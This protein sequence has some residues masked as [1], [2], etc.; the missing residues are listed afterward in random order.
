MLVS[1]L[2][3]K[4]SFDGLYFVKFDERKGLVFIHFRKNFRIRKHEDNL[5]FTVTSQTK[6][7]SYTCNQV[8]SP[9][10]FVQSDIK[11]QHNTIHSCLHDSIIYPLKM[12]R[13]CVSIF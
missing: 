1:Y 2:S 6:L 3:K 9:L 4:Y 12:Y 7:K 5:V 13:I 11:F 8:K 10:L